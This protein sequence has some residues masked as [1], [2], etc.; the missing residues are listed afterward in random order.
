M[1]STDTRRRILANGTHLG[2][3]QCL[4]VVVNRAILRMARV[5]RTSL[6][7]LLLSGQLWEHETLGEAPGT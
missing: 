7:W 6:A 3:H 1:A 4:L 2:L 5:S